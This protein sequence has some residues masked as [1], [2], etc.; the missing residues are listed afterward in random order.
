MK[1]REFYDKVAT[2]LVKQKLSFN[3]L[4]VKLVFETAYNVI[5]KDINKEKKIPLGKLGFVKL[6]ERKARKGRNPKTGE[7][8]QIPAGKTVRMRASNL[9]RR[10]LQS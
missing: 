2:G 9:M 6:V 8:I 7:T 10:S 1:R 3:A 4:A 5:V